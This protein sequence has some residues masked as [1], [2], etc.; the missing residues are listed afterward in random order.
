MVFKY[1]FILLLSLSLI[2]C[3]ANWKA[4]LE[5]RSIISSFDDGRVLAKPNIEKNI[6]LVKSG[7]TLYAIAWRTGKDYKDLARWNKISEPFKIYDGQ[8]LY[9]YPPDKNIKQK[10]KI[11][12]T[13]KNPSVEKYSPKKKIARKINLKT[14]GDLNW[15]WPAKGKVSSFFR[16]NDRGKKGIKLS[17]RVGDRVIAAENGKVVYSGS[18]LIGYG[19]LVIVKHNNDYLSAYGHN[20]EIFVSQGESVKKGQ[21]IAEIGLSNDGKPTLH[22]EI[23]KNGI[24]IDPIKVLPT[25]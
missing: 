19:K 20:R 17:G 14:E 2:A 11:E 21:K 24:P 8:Q 22:F 6:Y 16:L 9:L 1:L 13:K 10:N 5:T 3:S 7:D 18:G 4:P 25:Q 23:R 15:N 12:I